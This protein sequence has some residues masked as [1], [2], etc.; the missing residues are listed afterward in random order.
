MDKVYIDNSKKTEA[1]ELPKF[2]EVKLIVKD[3]KVV[4][5]DTITSHVL[6]KN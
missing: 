4:K 1:V 6:P 2:G 5:Y 3:G